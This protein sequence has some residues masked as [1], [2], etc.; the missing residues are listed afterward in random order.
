MVD[1]TGEFNKRSG[2]GERISLGTLDRTVD[3][4]A[5]KDKKDSRV[6][7]ASVCDMIMRNLR[8]SIAATNTLILTS[9]TVKN[10]SMFAL[11]Y[12]D[13]APKKGIEWTKIKGCLQEMRQ[14]IKHEGAIPKDNGNPVLKFTINA[15]K[16]SCHN[17]WWKGQTARDDKNTGLLARNYV[18]LDKDFKG[19]AFRRLMDP[20]VFAAARVEFAGIFSAVEGEPF[21]FA[22]GITERPNCPIVNIAANAPA[23]GQASGANANVL[24]SQAEQLRNRLNEK[25]LALSDIIEDIGGITGTTDAITLPAEVYEATQAF[26]DVSVDRSCFSLLQLTFLSPHPGDGGVCKQEGGPFH[27]TH[28]RPL[29]VHLR[30]R[31]YQVLEAQSWHQH[32]ALCQG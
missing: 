23:T 20:L 15:L 1:Q 9:P 5:K 24:L 25:M 4:Y 27:K 7:K 14:H 31:G 21:A 32:R 28:H 19:Y 8:T 30:P 2:K 3:F 10:D 29:Q 22:D 13:F 17:S 26:L 12:P 18:S 6:M 11:H 16:N